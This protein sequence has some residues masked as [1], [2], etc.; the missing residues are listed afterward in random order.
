MTTQRSAALLAAVGLLLGGRAYA[1]LLDSPPPSIGGEP[2]KVVYRMGPVHYYPGWVDTLVSCTNLGDAAAG[3]VLEIFDED[4]VL[5][6]TANSAQVPGGGTVTFTTSSGPGI[7]GAV[8]PAGLPALDHGK[9]R[10]S[11]TTAKLS[12]AAKSRV[13]GADGSVKEAPLELVK[14]VALGD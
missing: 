13:L 5:R 8:V 3:M 9:A 7:D 1:G 2:G 4:D 12:C 11:A 6:A 14:K 10:V